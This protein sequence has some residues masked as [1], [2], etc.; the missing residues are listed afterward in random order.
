MSSHVDLAHGQNCTE[1]KLAMKRHIYTDKREFGLKKQCG[2]SWTDKPITYPPTNPPSV[3]YKNKAVRL[4]LASLESQSFCELKRF[5][6]LPWISREVYLT[7]LK[8]V[9]NEQHLYQK[10]S[11]FSINFTEYNCH[12]IQCTSGMVTRSFT[13][14][15]GST[16][17]SLMREGSAPQPNPLSF[18]LIYHFCTP[19]IYLLLTNGTPFTYLPCS[20]DLCIPAINALS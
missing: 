1:N 13:D 3:A 5:L 10:V 8:S 11:L 15:R 18:K 7:F 16:P 20:L 14:P 6:Q 17:K 2:Q 4:H 9:C 19:F 12:D